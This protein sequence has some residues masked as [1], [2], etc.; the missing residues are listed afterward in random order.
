MMVKWDEWQGI[1]GQ[2]AEHAG[3]L[4]QYSVYVEVLNVNVIHHNVWMTSG[5]VVMECKSVAET[6]EK[7]WKG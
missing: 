5:G 1:T 2:L 4:T 7:L 6:C 3:W